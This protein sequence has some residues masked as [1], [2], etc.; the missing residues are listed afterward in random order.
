MGVIPTP[1]FS[2]IEIV[3]NELRPAIKNDGGDLELVAFEE[4]I[5]FLRLQGACAACPMSFYTLKM[6]VEV[7]LKSRVPA[8]REVRTVE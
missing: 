6:G 8:V 1:E 5:V 3:L 2:A 7:E 4:G